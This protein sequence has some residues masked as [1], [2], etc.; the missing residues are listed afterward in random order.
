[1]PSC[2]SKAAKI[3]L[4][5][6]ACVPRPETSAAAAPGVGASPGTGPA[7]S[8]W[9]TQGKPHAW[10]GA[11]RA[12]T[13]LPSFAVGKPGGERFTG[14]GHPAALPFHPC[15]PALKRTGASAGIAKEPAKPR[16]DVEGGQEVRQPQPG[17]LLSA[18]SPAKFLRGCL[19]P[20]C[21]GSVQLAGSVSRARVRVRS[22]TRSRGR[23]CPA[24][25]RM[26]V[27]AAPRSAAHAG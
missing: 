4:S 22:C 23:S 5:R 21:D 26:P 3:I 18:G 15:K 10:R 25:V 27:I 7:P 6:G 2:R 24:P 20:V 12:D 13:G 1:M 19:W 17:T 14:T 9:V 16:R 11:T 8:R